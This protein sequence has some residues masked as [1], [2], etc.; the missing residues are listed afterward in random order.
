MA[1]GGFA[2]N[3]GKGQE[4]AP[5]EE[6]KI[7]WGVLHDATEV[8]VVAMA[9]R[10]KMTPVKREKGRDLFFNVLF[11]WGRLTLGDGRCKFSVAT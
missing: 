10:L 1:L 2:V 6:K 5:W 8:P 11:N 4:E 7:V 9:L 3:E